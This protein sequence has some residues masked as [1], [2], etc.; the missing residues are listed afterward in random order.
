MSGRERGKRQPHDLFD[1]RDAVVVDHHVPLEDA[2]KVEELPEQ[3]RDAHARVQHVA[4]DVR[5]HRVA[6]RADGLRVLR[7]QKVRDLLRD[8]R[9][10]HDAD[11]AD[12]DEAE[13]GAE[14]LAL[15]RA[16]PAHCVAGYMMMPQGPRARA[17]FFMSVRPFTLPP[18]PAPSRRVHPPPPAPP[19]A[20]GGRWLGARVACLALI[21]PVLCMGRTTASAH[22]VAC[23]HLLIAPLA[24][25]S[26]QAYADAHAGGRELARLPTYLCRACLWLGNAAA[27]MLLAPASF[28]ATVAG[29]WAP[30]SHNVSA[31]AS[32]SAAEAFEPPHGPWI[33]LAHACV[34][35]ALCL[36]CMQLLW[37]VPKDHVLR[38]MACTAVAVM[39]AAFAIAASVAPTPLARRFFQAAAVPFLLLFMET[40][41]RHGAPD[42][43]GASLLA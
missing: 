27:L 16:E 15:V 8:A 35:L 14:R 5:L 1:R 18:Y 6:V 29:L 30:L 42:A 7:E 13:A 32:F 37:T 23:L 34:T 33:P 25:P 24:G 40:T 11:V 26:L 36:G 4:R 10:V 19:P 20:A 43:G 12:D 41:M 2:R 3:D 39:V 31:S 28:S 38:V 22:R 17:L 9:D 21:V